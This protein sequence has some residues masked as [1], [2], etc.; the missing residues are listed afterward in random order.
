MQQYAKSDREKQVLYDL[1]Y[2][3][4]IKTRLMGTE[5]RLVVARS[6]EGWEWGSTM[7]E[8]GQKVKKNQG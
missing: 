5:Y 6:S 3:C 7:G 8:G 4:T 2:M 1:T